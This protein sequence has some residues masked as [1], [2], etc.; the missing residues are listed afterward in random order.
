M[1]EAVDAAVGHCAPAAACGRGGVVQ[2]TVVPFVAMAPLGPEPPAT[3]VNS[4]LL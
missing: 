4:R 1:V 3:P 2:L